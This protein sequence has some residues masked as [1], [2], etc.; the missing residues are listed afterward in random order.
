[1]YRYIAHLFEQRCVNLEN[2]YRKSKFVFFHKYNFNC[3]MHVKFIT[4]YTY[5]LSEKVMT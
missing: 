1:M 5:R 4:D 2:G 3:N